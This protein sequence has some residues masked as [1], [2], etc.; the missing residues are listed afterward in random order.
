MYENKIS[1]DYIIIVIFFICISDMIDLERRKSM[2]KSKLYN[3]TLYVSIS[4]ELDEH[5]ANL[6]RSEFDDCVGSQ[7]FRQVIID[8]AGLQFMDSTGIGML[9]GRYK[10]LKDKGVPVFISN[11]NKHVDKIFSMTGIYD[12]M[13]KIS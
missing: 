5:N 7:G 8:L 3:K 12:I 6:I 2:L 1:G 9:I 4:G 13:P 10:L 11:P